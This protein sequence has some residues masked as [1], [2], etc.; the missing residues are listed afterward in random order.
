MDLATIIGFVLGLGLIVG[1]IALGNALPAFVDIPSIMIVFGGTIATTLVMERL[2]NVTGAIKV[3][4]HAIFQPAGD[5][6]KTITTIL[7]L[8]ATARKE[9]L[10][11]L[12]KV[13]IADP[14][15]AQGVRMAVDGLPEEQIVET[16]SAELISMKARHTR[17]QKLFKFM[18]ASAPS[19]GMIGTLIGLVQMLRSLDDPA[20]IG[21]SMAVALLTTFYGAVIAFVFCNPIAEKLDRRSQ[22]E[23]SNMKVVIAGVRSIVAGH[24]PAI[25]KDALQARLPPTKRQEE[26]A[27]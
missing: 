23:S 7:E 22:E 12:E 18:A 26:K 10:L 13:Q 16:L 19:M 25:V 8:S 4:R 11:A 9:G 20:T 21:P 17:G 27:A 6:T 2:E 14:F 5:V 24:N 3:A 15:L 1:S